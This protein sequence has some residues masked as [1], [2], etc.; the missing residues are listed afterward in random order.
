MTGCGN[1]HFTIP[2]ANPVLA[3][4]GNGGPKGCEKTEYPLPQEMNYEK[5]KGPFDNS[6]SYKEEP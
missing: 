2:P 4:A 3:K 1:I 5:G 6:N